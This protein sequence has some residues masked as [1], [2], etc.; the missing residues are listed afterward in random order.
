MRL[1]E[2]AFLSDFSG[3]DSSLS[4]E[5]DEGVGSLSA[6]GCVRLDNF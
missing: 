5:V 3:F 1:V 6:D 2:P 4:P